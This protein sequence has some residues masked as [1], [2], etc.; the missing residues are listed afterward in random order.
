MLRYRYD[1]LGR[2]RIIK[3]VYVYD[4]NKPYG[5]AYYYYNNGAIA[6]SII[7]G[8]S[9]LHYSRKGDLLL[10]QDTINKIVYYFNDNGFVSDIAHYINDEEQFDGEI[11]IYGESQLTL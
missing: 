1:H 11:L 5:E 9:K 3:I 7:Y 8:V 2:K 6:K 4:G 10:Y